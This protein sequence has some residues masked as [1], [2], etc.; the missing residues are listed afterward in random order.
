MRSVKIFIGCLVVFIVVLMTAPLLANPPALPALPS[1][2]VINQVISQSGGPTYTPLGVPVNV[3]TS[4]VLFGGKFEDIE[5]KVSRYDSVSYIATGGAIKETVLPLK[6]SGSQPLAAD[7]MAPGSNSRPGKIVGA[8][9]QPYRGTMV[10]V[11]VFDGTKPDKIRMYYT[12]TKY[13]E[14]SLKVDKFKSKTAGTYDEGAIIA[15]KLSCVTVG[16]SQVCWEPEN[17]SAVREEP[18]PKNRIYD[19]YTRAKNAY[20]L[21]VDFFVDDAVPDLIG[22]TKR[23][24][25]SAALIA[26]SSPLCD[27]NLYVSAAKKPVAG[28][29][30]ALWVVDE[31]ADLK[32]FKY[33]GTYRGNIPAG[34]YLVVN[35]T[36]NITTPGQIGV[37]MLVNINSS[38]HY[39]IP[40]IRI[41]QFAQSSVFQD[42]VASIKDGC[43][44]YYGW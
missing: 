37:L 40:S 19:A 17:Y 21:Q 25:C 38:Q 16:I 23:T 9:Y 43:T 29:P 20:D 13:Y 36:P 22:S 6:S 28:Q 24:L 7:M 44:W 27:P 15:H 11:V 33:D 26:A 31:Q 3:M 12:N 5:N 39:L 42:P 2:T 4:L 10:L 41:Q 8:L 35:A 32:G 1:S 18:Y 14:Y 30:I 34:E